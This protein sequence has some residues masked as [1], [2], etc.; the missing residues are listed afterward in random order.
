MGVAKEKSVGLYVHLA[1][2]LLYAVEKAQ[3]VE[4]AQGE[5]SRLV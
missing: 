3:L 2:L 5:H 1:Y 4:V